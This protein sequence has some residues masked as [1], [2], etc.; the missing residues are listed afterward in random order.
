MYILCMYLIHIYYI[1]IYIYIYIK[2]K[3][4][5]KFFALKL[6]FLLI[7]RMSKKFKTNK[8]FSAKNYL[9]FI[10]FTV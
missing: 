7:F 3:H 1:Y 9:T 4:E 2:L 5:I 10:P 8:R 6:S